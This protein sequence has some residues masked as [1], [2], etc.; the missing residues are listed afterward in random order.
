MT[1]IGDRIRRGR[2]L[3]NLTQQALADALRIS[4]VS[5]TQWEGDTT[6]P[7]RDRI[8]KLA[9]VLDVSPDWLLSGDGPA[10]TIKDNMAGAA[11]ITKP[12]AS[13]PPRYERFPQTQR[14]PLKEQ[15]VGGP[16]GRFVLGDASFGDVFCPPM[17]EG[18][19]GAYAVRV[20]GTS[21]E[22]RFKAGE[23]VWLN[24]HEPIR[25]GDDVVAQLLPE[26]DDQ[27]TE[28]YIKEFR[29]RSNSVLRLWQ[30]NPE[31]GEPNELEFDGGRVF[32]VHKV[33]FH[34]MV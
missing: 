33:V 34:A 8:A 2:K 10:P 28:S 20:Y 23:T 5:V 22:P 24:P 32:Q 11:T 16:N 17:L 13:Y 29:F 3:R 9:Q 6:A 26:D 21:M 25:A 1:T 12:N 4:R 14:I 19:E 31:D 15:T 7:E 30:H 27:P 18:V